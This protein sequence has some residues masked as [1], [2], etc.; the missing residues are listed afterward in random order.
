MGVATLL[1]KER[2]GENSFRLNFRSQEELGFVGGQY[3]IIDSKM[4]IDEKKNYKR[5][6][7]I[8]SSDKEQ[9]QFSIAY[10]E[11]ESG[12]VTNGFL[13]EIAKGDEVKFSGPWGKFLKEEKYAKTGG[14]LI[15][16]TDTAISTAIS[17]LQSSKVCERAC[18]VRLK[19]F[20]PSENYFLCFSEVTRNMPKDIGEFEIILA[21][22]FGMK[23]DDEF[24]NNVEELLNKSNEASYL[25]CGDGRIVKNGKDL[26]LKKGIPEIQ[27]GTK[28]YF[29]KEAI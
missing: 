27:I 26:L 24:Y 10:K 28:T 5:A 18:D 23:R 8:I 25:L 4:P 16:A 7:T 19:W 17:F 2:I 15:I 21:P 3:I 20:V 11:I 6:Y 9:F 12:V 22:N 29:N 14:L 1:S 13:K